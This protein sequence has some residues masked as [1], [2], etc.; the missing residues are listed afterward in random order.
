MA[1]R[2]LDPLAADGLA[3]GPQRGVDARGTKPFPVMS[4][5]PPDLAQEP[6]IGTLARALRP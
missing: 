6:T 2:P 3:C 1:H 4:M 5:N